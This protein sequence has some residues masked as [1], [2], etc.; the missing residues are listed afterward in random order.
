MQYEV[1]ADGSQANRQTLV[2]LYRAFATGDLGTVRA[3][4]T[5]GINLR[6][7]GPSP[8]A[9][10]YRG[11]EA[12]LGFFRKMMAPYAGTLRVEVVAVLADDRFGLVRWPN[13]RASWR[14]CELL[15]VR[16]WELRG[17]RCARFESLCD[18]A[19]TRSW[20]ARAD[21]AGGVR[22]ATGPRCRSDPGGM[23]SEQ[24]REG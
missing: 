12:G 14:G 19:Y 10:V 11:R 23:R 5:D 16:I 21:A 13:G 9:S 15:G 8:V 22:V 6:V 17:G 7:N 3:T 1:T 2:A 18:D 24:P 4:L 20:A